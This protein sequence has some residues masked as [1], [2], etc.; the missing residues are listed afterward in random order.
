MIRRP[1][2]ISSHRVLHELRYPHSTLWAPL[3]EPTLY[4]SLYI[5]AS[6]SRSISYLSSRTFTVEL[7]SKGWH[8]WRTYGDKEDIKG[9]YSSMSSVTLMIA[10][11]L[12][13]ELSKRDAAHALPE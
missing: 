8:Y 4:Y 10:R 5:G 7:R 9:P 12:K 1:L 2:R 3:R 13:R 6:K 11:E